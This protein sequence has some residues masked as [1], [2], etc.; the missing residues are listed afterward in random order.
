MWL[1]WLLFVWLLVLAGVY[2]ILRRGDGS[3]DL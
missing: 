2:G 1:D 3:P